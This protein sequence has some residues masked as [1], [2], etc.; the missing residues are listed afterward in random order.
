MKRTLFVFLLLLVLMSCL[1]YSCKEQTPT[2]TL[3]TQAA[4][5]E[6]TIVPAPETQTSDLA[7]IESNTEEGTV[8]VPSVPYTLSHTVVDITSIADDAKLVV[9]GGGMYSPDGQY[10]YH[11]T[12]LMDGKLMVYGYRETNGNRECGCLLSI[13]D[14]VTEDI[15]AVPNIGG[16]IPYYAYPLSDGSFAVL[17]SEGPIREELYYYFGVTQSDGTLLAKMNLDEVYP[18]FW[19]NGDFKIE[20]LENEQAR[21]ESELCNPENAADYELMMSLTAE[22]E[23]IKAKILTAMDVW[24]Q[25]SS[26]IE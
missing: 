19:T 23:E 5:T 24:E 11:T 13:R 18:D 22:L 9:D 4:I 3:Q 2:I 15:I 8:S 26:E 14:G 25:I 12:F 21:L 10:N 20:E 1:M 17:W 16:A 7:L 6:A